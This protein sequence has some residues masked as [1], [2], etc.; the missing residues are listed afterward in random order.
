MVQRGNCGIAATLQRVQAAGGIATVLVN[1]QL[2]RLVSFTVSPSTVDPEISSV[3][4]LSIPSVSVSLSDGVEM[5]YLLEREVLSARFEEFTLP[6]RQD[7]VSAFSS[8]GPTNDGRLGL[9]ILAPGMRAEAKACPVC[10]D[11][12]VTEFHTC[13]L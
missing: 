11:A 12:Y 1:D 10:L 13:L 4:E 5:Q 7:N 9:H 3:S 6:N 2:G 8:Y